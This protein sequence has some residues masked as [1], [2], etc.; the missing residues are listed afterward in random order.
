MPI[1]TAP[2]A[3]P[4]EM[5]IVISKGNEQTPP[6][7]TTTNA[8]PDYTLPDE[9]AG[10]YVFPPL[11]NELVNQFASKQLSTYSAVSAASKGKIRY[12]CTR[13][14]SPRPQS[15]WLSRPDRSTTTRLTP[16]WSLF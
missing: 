13:H 8:E 4:N 9:G 11:T 14:L 1:D 12:R 7:N 15:N 10:D 3:N 2:P 6:P 5:T 16:D